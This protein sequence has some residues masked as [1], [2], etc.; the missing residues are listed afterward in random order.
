MV[1]TRL[2]LKVSDST[3]NETGRQ[4]R[5]IITVQKSCHVEKNPELGGFGH[6]TSGV[7]KACIM[8]KISLT[9]FPIVLLF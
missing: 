2:R 9:V 5:K 1:T 4:S 3:L 7:L 6:N 8:F